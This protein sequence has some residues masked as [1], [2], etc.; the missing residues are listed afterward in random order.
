MRQINLYDLDQAG[1]I[2]LLPSGVKFLN[3]VG[4]GA[5]FQ[6]EAEGIFFPISHDHSVGFGEINER[7]EFRFDKIFST[8]EK[9]ENNIADEIDAILHELP[10]T[11]GISVDRTKL[12]KSFEAWIYVKIND[13]ELS[14]YKGFE[15]A[16]AILTWSNS[17]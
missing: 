16:K 3:Q 1:I 10:S 11:S 14:A 12:D 2:V 17:D 5:C 8:G 13:T 9:V 15:N 7:L 6:Y 4:G